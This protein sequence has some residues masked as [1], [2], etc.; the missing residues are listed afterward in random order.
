MLYMFAGNMQTWI[1]AIELADLVEK[2][3]YN[4]ANFIN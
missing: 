1:E 3:L 4:A 2:K